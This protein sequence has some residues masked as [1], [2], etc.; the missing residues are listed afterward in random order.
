MIDRTPA[1][2]RFDTRR[3]FLRTVALGSVLAACAPGLRAAL[4]R[5]KITRVRI[6][7][8]PN[9]NPL[10]NQSNMVVT[11]ETD[12]GIT[13]VGEGGS[14]DTL[15]QCAERL[16]GRNPFEIERCWQDMYRS[17][18]YPPGREKTHALGALDLALW[19]I[20]GKAL[21]APVHELLGGM[22][23]THI[24]CYPTGGWRNLP[25]GERARAAMQAGFRA[26]R[27]NAAD[28]PAGTS[29]FQSR[30]AVRQFAREAKAVREGVGAGGDWVVDFHQRFD[31]ADAVRAC[32]LAE[33][34]EPCFIED[35]VR[36]EAFLE[37]IPK[38]RLLTSAPLSAGE[39][40]GVRWEF[41]KLIENHD[42]DYVRATLPNVGGITELVKIAALC[43]THNVGL[44][45]HFTGPI[46]TAALVHVLG[47]FSGPVLMEWL[48]SA[49]QHPH[50]SEWLDFKDGR[51]FA[52]QRPGLGVTLDPK[53]LTQVSEITQRGPDRPIYF[54]PDGSQTNW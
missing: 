6:Y 16:I 35:P 31:F 1:T 8:P 7:R 48:M 26:F 39:Q 42:I 30:E 27:F 19:D 43:E 51:I 5:A 40:W 29:V 10:F 46:A 50:L 14:K 2:P 17:F 20:K 24:E 18:F 28:V 32:R 54:R 3:R 25:L 36:M 44:V 52:N 11:V 21:D 9:L 23:R 45:P 38:L 15:E 33:E 13:G 37:D 53:P 47:P 22:N 41:N 49:T 12:A 34:F 4:P